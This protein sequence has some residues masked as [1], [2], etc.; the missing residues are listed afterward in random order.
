LHV[1]RAV[2]VDWLLELLF[3]LDE[4]GVL[5]AVFWQSWC[6]LD[7]AKRER[8]VG[9]QCVHRAFVACGDVGDDDAC[10]PLEAFGT[11]IDEE[12]RD[13]SLS[14]SPRLLI[15]LVH[16]TVDPTACFNVV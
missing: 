5:D 1:G 13:A 14:F 10:L 12:C 9:R 3:P 7:G 11:A 2:L 16:H 4:Q 15:N 6:L 8:V